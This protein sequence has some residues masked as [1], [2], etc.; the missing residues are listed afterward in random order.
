LLPPCTVHH[1]GQVI[2]LSTN[3]A[4]RINYEQPGALLRRGN[5]FLQFVALRSSP[6]R[7]ATDAPTVPHKCPPKPTASICAPQTPLVGSL[8]AYKQALSRRL[9][10]T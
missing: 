9:L 1:S 2:Y 8:V 6:A 3:L 4:L 10:C 5:I 7:S